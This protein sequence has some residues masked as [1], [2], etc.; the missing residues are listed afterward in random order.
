MNNAPNSASAAD[1]ITASIICAI[2][3]IAP[4]FGGFWMS[5][6]RERNALLPYFEIWSRLSTPHHYG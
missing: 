6:L 5:L 4:L 1:D 2:V 3:N